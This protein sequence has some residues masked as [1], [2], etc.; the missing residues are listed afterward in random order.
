MPNSPMNRHSMKEAN[1][2]IVLYTIFIKKKSYLKLIYG[3]SG[4][5]IKMLRFINFK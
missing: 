3:L 2:K 5:D 4:N 1:W